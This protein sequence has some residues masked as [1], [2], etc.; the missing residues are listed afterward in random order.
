MTDQ[1]IKTEPTLFTETC[2]SLFQA[3]GDM[4]SWKAGLCDRL[5]KNLV[6]MS[7]QPEVFTDFEQGKFEMV[8][9]N[10]ARRKV[11][12]QVHGKLPMDS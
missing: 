11:L 7:I 8:I 5:A 12:L 1:T 9:D 3:C 6:S 2:S 10:Y 4:S